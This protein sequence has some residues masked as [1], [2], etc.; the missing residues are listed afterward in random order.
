MRLIKAIIRPEN[1]GDVIG[2]LFAAGF[3]AVTN[4][5]VTGCG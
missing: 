1:S 5:D 4:M 2:A 3:P